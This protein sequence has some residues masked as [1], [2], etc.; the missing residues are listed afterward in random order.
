MIKISEGAEAE[1]Y[2]SSFAGIGAVIKRRLRKRYRVAALDEE[3]R[4]E[5]TRRE[6]RLMSAANLGGVRTPHVLL[7]GPQEL[8]MERIAGETLNRILERGGTVRAEAFETAG[9]Y[10]GLL[11]AAGI[12]HGDY[13][14]A[15]IMLDGRMVYVIDFGLG[16]R[17]LGEEDRAIDLL[18]MKR[19]IRMGS[20]RA[21]VRG[22]A[23][24]FAGSGRVLERLGEIEERGR[25]STRTLLTK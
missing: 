14:P 5:R 19:S 7:V 17:S 16:G 24:A 21:F 10:L 13:T 8:W 6:A 12:V 23:G 18:L 11:H 1:L 20:Y 3:I 2:A 25:Y 22:Y 15:N 4:S 9:A